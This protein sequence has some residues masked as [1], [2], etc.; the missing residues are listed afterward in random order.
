MADQ[1]EEVIGGGRAIIIT[2]LVIT[3]VVLV[4]F[5]LLL[6]TAKLPQGCVER[7]W[8]ISRL[9]CLEPN[10]IGDTFAGV[11]A[12]VAF[13]W[14]VAAVFLQRN[15]LS[16]QRLELKQ[17]RLVAAEQVIEA[18]RNVALIEQQ[19]AILEMQRQI[20]NE[21]RFDEHVDMLIDVAAT[22]ADNLNGSLIIRH[23]SGEQYL[24]VRRVPDDPVQTLKKFIE[25]IL[26]ISDSAKRMDEEN[27]PIIVENTELIERLLQDLEDLQ[28]ASTKASAP[29]GARV[30]QLR[31]RAGTKACAMLLSYGEELDK[32]DAALVFF[33]NDP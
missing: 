6:S 22:T 32:D 25:Q 12:P 5:V 11:F 10:A 29:V 24:H 15:E 1:K 7:L 19:T 23:T 20:D 4:A 31:V 2:S 14:L 3:A 28:V 17:S 8:L 13:V 26:A 33:A 9:Q 27:G 30:R 21:R 16:A 18:R